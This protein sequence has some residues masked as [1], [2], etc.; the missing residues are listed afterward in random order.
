MVCHAAETFQWLSGT[1]TEQHGATW[2][3]KESNEWFGCRKNQTNG[4]SWGYNICL[5]FNPCSTIE[6]KSADFGIFS[7]VPMHLSLSLRYGGTSS[8]V[9]EIK[10]PHLLEP[11]P[12]L[13]Y[14][15]DGETLCHAVLFSNQRSSKFKRAQ[16]DLQDHAD[17]ASIPR[18]QQGFACQ[19]WVG[20]WEGL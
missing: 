6:L 10:P 3:Q 16:A 8:E 20:W 17:L 12:C 14:M 9:S 11:A 2:M 13:K 1:G 7:W 18:H 19:W 4:L 5:K 15:C